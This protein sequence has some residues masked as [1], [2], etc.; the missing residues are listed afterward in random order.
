MTIKE[1]IVAVGI[2]V[3]LLGAMAVTGV[4]LLASSGIVVQL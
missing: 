4:I 3:T 2:S 1:C